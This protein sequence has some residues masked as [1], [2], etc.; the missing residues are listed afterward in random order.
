MMKYPE[1]MNDKRIQN[2]KIKWA[3]TRDQ[4]ANMSGFKAKKAGRKANKNMRK[5]GIKWVTFEGRKINYLESKS[6]FYH[7]ILD[8]QWAKLKQNRQ[9]REILLKTDYLKLM[10][11]HHQYPNSPQAWKYN[12]IWMKIRSKLL[13]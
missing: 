7:L 9:V 8:V 6:E 13:K 4:V 2:P 1:G 5:L 11:D 3:Y 12:E 10:P